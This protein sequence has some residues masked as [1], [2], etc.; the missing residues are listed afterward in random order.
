MDKITLKVRGMTCSGCVAAVQRVLH[1][2]DGV[3][4]AQ[5]S[6]SNGGEA[7]VEYEPARVKPAD[8]QTAIEDAGYEVEA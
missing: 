2:V 4:E 8:L 6:L 3:G 7:T 5:V 1:E